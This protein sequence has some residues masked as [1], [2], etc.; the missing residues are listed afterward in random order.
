MCRNYPAQIGWIN[1]YGYGTV[2]FEKM[3]TSDE[4]STY[5]AELGFSI[6]LRNWVRLDRGRS[7]AVL[8]MVLGI[9]IFIMQVINRAQ[10]NPDPDL[11][12]HESL[13]SSSAQNV[14]NIDWVSE[15]HVITKE[16]L[17]L[18]TQFLN[19]SS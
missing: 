12:I 8:E 11:T 13:H 15:K 9:F 1:K 4:A 2:D 7:H 17:L 16:G 19:K 18:S 3:C 10:A 6:P 14:L 5:V